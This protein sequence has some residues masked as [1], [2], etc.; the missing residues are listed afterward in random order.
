MKHGI[1]DRRSPVS[2]HCFSAAKSGR[3]RAFPLCVL[4]CIPMA[5]QKSTKK[6]LGGS[7]GTPVRNPSPRAIKI[8]IA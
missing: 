2:T 8:G 3:H 4:L 1:Y 5:S 6:A 7:R